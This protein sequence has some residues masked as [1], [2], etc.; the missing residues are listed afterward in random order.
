MTN[1]NMLYSNWCQAENHSNDITL[2]G[3]DSCRTG[4][5]NRDTT[6]QKSELWQTTMAW[7]VAAT[8]SPLAAA[9]AAAVAAVAA[10]AA[11]IRYNV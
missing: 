4:R 6:P 7:S 2:L 3:S 8:L 10:A 1:A 9:V 5:V 11:V